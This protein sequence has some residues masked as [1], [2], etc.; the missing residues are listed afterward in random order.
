MEKK[1]DHQEIINKI[2]PELDKVVSFFDREVAKIRASRAS[3]SLVEDIQVEC[4]GQ[5][6]L[7]KQL[8][9]I[10]TPEP[11]QISIQPW[12]NS[13]IE[14]IV[15]ALSKSGSGISPV[16][17]QNLIRISIPPL[18]EEYRQDL[19]RLLSEKIDEAKKTIRHWREMAWGEIQEGFQI[20]EIREDD[21]YRGKDKLQELVD[22]YN[23]KLE[24]LAEKKKKEI[25]E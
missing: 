8:G 20:G 13:Y 11:R 18:S 1:R 16:V 6:F 10:S 25:L 3:A 15:N 23:E 4:F 21:K 22:E 12:D 2:K 17:D 19:L 7:L 14:P 9:V 5:K 24:E